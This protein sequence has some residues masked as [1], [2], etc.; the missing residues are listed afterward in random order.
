MNATTLSLNPGLFPQAL[1]MLAAALVLF[2]LSLARLAPEKP[3][4]PSACQTHQRTSSNEGHMNTEYPMRICAD[5]R[6]RP[7]PPRQ[8]EAQRIA[9]FR[10]A[11]IQQPDGCLVY[12]CSLN[13]QAGDRG[14]FKFRNER[15]QPARLAYFLA[16]GEIP[17]GQLVCHSCDEGRCCNVEHLFLGTQTDNMRDMIAKGRAKHPAGEQHERARLTAEQVVEIRRRMAEREWGDGAKIAREFGITSP[18]AFRIASRVI[19]RS[20]P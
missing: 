7:I 1:K 2:N 12:K 11:L 20:L 18:H 3:H 17:K 16:H 4:C 8:T 10:A 6:L 15:W 19:W 5:R 13:K 14:E 9:K